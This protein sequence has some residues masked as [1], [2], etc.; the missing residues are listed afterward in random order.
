MQTNN[1]IEKVYELLERYEFTELSEIDRQ[2]VLS[3]MNED[4]Y[5]KMR[6]IIDNVKI[7]LKGEIEP[8]KSN[9]PCIRQSRESK[10]KH[11]LNYELK[12]YKVAA[13]IVI[14]VTIFFLF[15]HSNSDNSNQVITKN[16]IITICHIDTVHTIIYD[17]VEIIKTKLNYTQSEIPK[18]E[19]NELISQS[20]HKNDCSNSLCPN[21]IENISVMNSRNPIS[22][23]ST[24][25]ELLLTFN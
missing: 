16:D 1:T 12:V 25:K 10:L 13:I 20:I 7:E 15:K 17:T 11:F 24:T 22:I 2:H 19:M 5:S 8:V 14:L 3:V 9:P 23:D 6:K 18:P 4:E 21:E